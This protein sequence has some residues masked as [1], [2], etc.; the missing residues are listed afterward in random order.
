MKIVYVSHA[1]IPSRT[2]NS[3]QIMKMV[4]ALAE[5]GYDVTLIAP[6]RREQVMERNV[7]DI[8]QFYGVKRNFKLIKFPSPK[9]KCGSWLSKLSVAAYFCIQKPDLVYGRSIEGVLWGAKLGFK[10][11]LEQHKPFWEKRPKKKMKR[12]RQILDSPGFR[13]LVVNC[14]ALKQMFLDTIDGLSPDSILVA[15]NAA[16]SPQSTLKPVRLHGD[17]RKRNIGYTGH[18]YKGK[19]VEMIAHIAGELKEYNFHIIGGMDEDIHYWR[20]HIDSENVFFY[21]F[22]PHAEVPAYIAA[23]DVCLLPIKRDVRGFGRNSSNIAS[24]TSPIKMFEYMAQGKLIIASDMPVLREVLNEDN[25][26]LLDPE[27]KTAWIETIRGLKR[28]RI[29][30]LGKKAYE[31]FVR[32]YTW[33]LRAEKIINALS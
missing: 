10:I 16:D 6:A 17:P 20:E 33:Q 21:G 3:L 31:D 27:D 19:G 1:I 24:Y 7:A 22:V 23:T 12:F 9:I 4:S 30:L 15:H 26:L 11:G 2:A 18:L 14:G 32:N 13:K 5:H 8:H 29:D 28:E 25:A